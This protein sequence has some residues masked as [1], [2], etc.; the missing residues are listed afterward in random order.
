VREKKREG[1]PSFIEK[2]N[3]HE[4]ITSERSWMD[5]CVCVGVGVWGCVD[6][7]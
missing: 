5:I 2:K 7:D 6:R 1:M 3:F 4:N